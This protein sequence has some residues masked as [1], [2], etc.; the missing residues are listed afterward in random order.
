MFNIDLIT[1]G[2]DENLAKIDGSTGI[3]INQLNINLQNG[4]L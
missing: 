1:N 3:I 2:L 4:N